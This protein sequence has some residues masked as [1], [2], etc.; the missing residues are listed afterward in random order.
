MKVTKIALLSILVLTVVIAIAMPASA[1]IVCKIAKVAGDENTLENYVVQ[2]F[3]Q[4]VERRTKG[5]IDVQPFFGNAFGSGVQMI[6]NVKLGTLQGTYNTL[7]SFTTFVPQGSVVSLPFIFR[8]EEHALKVTNGSLY[9]PLA[10]YFEKNGFHASAFWNVGFRNPL[11]HYAINTVADAKGKKVRTKNDPV[12]I[13][14]WKAVGA[15]PT[16]LPWADVRNAMD[17]KTIDLFTTLGSAYWDM[18]LYEFAPYYSQ[19][20]ITYVAYVLAFDLKWWNKLSPEHQAIID[21][22]ARELA[23][24]QHHLIHYMNAKGPIL[25]KK[26]GAKVNTVLDVEPFAAKMKPLWSDWAKEVEGGQA[27]IDTIRNTK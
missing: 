4:I 19:L 12:A 14:L 24:M 1:K 8:D 21:E 20:G 15:N 2:R 17:T 11:G 13:K 25:A 6:E 3:E 16:P 27:L 7:A 10:A 22:T 26:T 23:V 5:E 18:K 9:K